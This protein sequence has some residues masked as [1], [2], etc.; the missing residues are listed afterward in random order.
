MLQ[1]NKELSTLSVKAWPHFFDGLVYFTDPQFTQY[2]DGLPEQMV[3]WISKMDHLH[4]WTTLLGTKT[5]QPFR[6]KK[7]TPVR[8][9]WF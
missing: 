6:G 4:A 8:I 9:E 5:N 7:K 2:H 3:K 1:L